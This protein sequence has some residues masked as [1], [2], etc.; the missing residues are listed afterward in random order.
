MPTSPSARLFFALWPDESLRRALA[1][2]QQALPLRSGRRVAAENLHVTLRFLGA[3]PQADIA[4]LRAAAGAIRATPFRLE[5]SRLGLWRKSGI[6]WLAPAQTPPPLHDLVRRINRLPG[7]PPTDY[8]PHVT[9][10]RKA[11]HAPPDLGFPPFLWRA[12]AFHLVESLTR[13]EGPEYRL[14][15]SWPLRGPPPSGERSA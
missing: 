7:P 1:D 2:F 4:A 13:A 8:H 9:L 6:V 14:L 5:L 11:A 10:L 15:A 3:V 12:E